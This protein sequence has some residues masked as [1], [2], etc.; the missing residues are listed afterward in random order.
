MIF[1]YSGKN[2]PHARQE[3]KW[4]GTPMGFSIFSVKKEGPL[5]I[6]IL[7]P[8]HCSPALYKTLLL[9]SLLNPSLK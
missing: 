1:N 6:K 5:Q 3:T 4:K 7:L 8:L 2:N 9:L